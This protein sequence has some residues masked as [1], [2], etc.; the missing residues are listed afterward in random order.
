MELRV[1]YPFLD[2]YLKNTILVLLDL[3]NN[4]PKCP[5]SAAN[6]LAGVEPQPFLTYNYIYIALCVT[7]VMFTALYCSVYVILVPY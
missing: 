3:Q 7:I 2:K 5:Q 4:P 6:D 1:C